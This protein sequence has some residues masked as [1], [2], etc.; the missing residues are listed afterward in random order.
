MAVKKSAY[1][2]EGG[3]NKRK[4]GEDF[5]F[6]HKFTS[7]NTLGEI[8]STTVLPSARVSD[9]VPFGTGK[10]IKDRLDGDEPGTYNPQSYLALVALIN[11]V[12]FFYTSDLK[13][14]DLKL[15]DC[16]AKYLTAHN[17]DN[18]ITEI[19]RNTT[20]KM[21]FEK[22]FWQWFNAFRL[23]KYLHYSRDN[24]YPN[25]AVE[26]AGNYLYNL[27]GNTT[28]NLS[29]EELLLWFRKYDKT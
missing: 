17:F 25:M 4:A 7:K 26:E 3:M 14:Q 13:L 9:R 29:A 11:K 21:A 2:K 20:S 10:A 22:R 5:Y 16:L 12:A 15:D 27:L 18:V 19:K 6:I 24:Y 1:I 23:M 28:A 8:K